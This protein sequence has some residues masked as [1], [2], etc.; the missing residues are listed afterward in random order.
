MEEVLNDLRRKANENKVTSTNQSSTTSTTA[1]MNSYKCEVCKDKGLVFINNDTAKICSC[2][3]QRKIDRL[4]KTSHITE[5]FTKL[6]F[7][8]FSL[9]GKH[10]SVVHAQRTSLA[11]VKRYGEL[12][13]S[14]ENSIALLGNP[15][16]GK[17]HL[18][19]AIS[20]NLLQ[21][22]VPVLYFPFREGFDA[23]KDDF[24]SMEGKIEQMKQV[25]VL[26]IDD[27]FKR[28][29]TEFEVKTMYSVI[30][31]RYLNHKP[32]LISSECLI[33]DLL[34]ID[35]ALGS[36]IYQMCKSYLVEIVGSR[37]ELNHRLS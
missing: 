31:Y 35:E 24:D 20:N 26:F 13:E 1:S 8:N 29:A 28:S 25:E 36:R 10:S 11:Y 33:D 37:R 7:K 34:D 18:L 14:R 3:E 27:L 32:L 6:G 22:K 5:E 15:G 21:K 30:N 2:R 4:F 16:A 9:E 17:T 12:K 23:F 19:T